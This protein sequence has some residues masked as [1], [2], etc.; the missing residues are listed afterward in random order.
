MLRAEEQSI[1]TLLGALSSFL[2]WD[3]RP[4]LDTLTAVIPQLVAMLS[5]TDNTKIAVQ[6]CQFL[7]YLSDGGIHF[8]QSLL[9]AGANNQL[10]LLLTKSDEKIVAA[11]L[12]A[13]R[14]LTLMKNTSQ[15]YVS[16]GREQSIK[17]GCDHD[18][19]V[20][21][22]TR[23]KTIGHDLSEI[24]LIICQNTELFKANH[25]DVSENENNFAET[26]LGYEGQV[27]LRCVHCGSMP[28]ARAHFSIVFP[29]MYHE[30]AQVFHKCC[31]SH[32]LS[33]N[34]FRQHWK[35]CS[36]FASHGRITFL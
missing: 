33:Y 35:F 27:G 7:C 11:A 16:C 32:Y 36:K 1:E 6:L 13:L 20:P 5:Q 10:R 4:P 21:L 22:W 8:A 18:W 2:I 25:D 28:F 9:D 12:Q 26:G 31:F 24:D 34:I 29:G 30:R 17:S 14:H 15:R 3:V 23:L 19:R